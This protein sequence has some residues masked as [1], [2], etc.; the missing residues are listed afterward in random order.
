[1]NLRTWLARF[2]QPRPPRQAD[3]HYGFLPA[4]LALAET[5]PLPLPASRR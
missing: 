4:H 3:T 1:M 2:R 5:P